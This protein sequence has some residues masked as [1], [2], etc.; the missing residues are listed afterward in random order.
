MPLVPNNVDNH[1][2]KNLVQKLLIASVNHSAS[3]TLLRKSDLRLQW[4]GVTAEK[5]DVR[6]VNLLYKYAKK[7]KCFS[8]EQFATDFSCY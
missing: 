3:A 8:E 7:V 1:Q 5:I 4:G 2:A 6:N